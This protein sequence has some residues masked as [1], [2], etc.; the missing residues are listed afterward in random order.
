MKETVSDVFFSNPSPLASKAN[1]K[2]SWSRGYDS[3]LKTKEY[4]LKN[5]WVEDDFVLFFLGSG[6]DM[7]GGFLFWTTGSLY[8]VMEMKVLAI[9][10][11]SWWY[12]RKTNTSLQRWCL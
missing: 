2:C 6:Q 3:P 4:S 11:K 9:S 10:L 1:T 5:G 12:P 8:Y 7:F